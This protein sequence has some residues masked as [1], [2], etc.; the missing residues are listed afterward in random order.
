[1]SPQCDPPSYKDK[2][3]LILAPK[4]ITDL[5]VPPELPSK[6]GATSNEGPVVKA[7]VPNG[8]PG[9]N[10]T[11]IASNDAGDDNSSSPERREQTVNCLNIENINRKEK[12]MKTAHVS[13][14]RSSVI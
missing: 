4:P 10:A 7:S 1:M 12:V 9:K 13:S 11:N 5:S 3:K 2:D 8:V 14:V 6:D